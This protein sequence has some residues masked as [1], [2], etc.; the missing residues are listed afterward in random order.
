MAKFVIKR[1]GTKEPFDPGKIKKSIEFAVR[2]SGNSVD[3][4][5]E[6][7]NQVSSVALEFAAEKEEVVTIK[8]TKI[9]FK[10]LEKVASPAAV[11]WR[12]YE[13]EKNR[14]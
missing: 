9:I 14:A 4:V 12:K 8:L 10:E 13:E 3:K 1:D 2:N 6:V 7:V 5:D 11:V